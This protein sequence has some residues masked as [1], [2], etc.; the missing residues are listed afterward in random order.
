MYP[1]LIEEIG[2]IWKNFP[3]QLMS[4]RLCSTYFADCW[5]PRPS[6]LQYTHWRK[7]AASAAATWVLCQPCR[8]PSL[9]ALPSSRA[10][11][12][13]APFFQ[14]KLPAECSQDIT[15][16]VSIHFH[17][18]VNC[19]SLTAQF[20]YWQFVMEAHTVKHCLPSSFILLVTYFTHPL[21][22]Q[23]GYPQTFLEIISVPT[24]PPFSFWRF[25]ISATFQFFSDIMEGVEARWGELRYHTAGG[26]TTR[27]RVA[28]PGSNNVAFSV[29]VALS[30]GQLRYHTAGGSTTSP[31]ISVSEMGNIGNSRLQRVLFPQ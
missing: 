29:Q 25:S 9:A 18:T 7:S 3:K 1:G 23:G 11:I 16:Q 14:K 2:R 8:R 15:K 30:R 28:Q 13:C 27:L 5:C 12:V 17:P 26:S 4:K 31:Q 6:G 10:H 24:P 19:Q 21:S 20:P 22:F